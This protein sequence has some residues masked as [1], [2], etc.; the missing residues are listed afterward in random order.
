MNQFPSEET[1]FLLQGPAGLIEVLTSVPLHSPI[2]GSAIICHPHPLFGGT[3]HNKVVTMLARVFHDLGLRT[4][5]FNFRGIGKS[6]GEHDG[7][8]GETDDV[9]TIAEWI[10]TVCPEEALWLAGFSFGG[11]VA[12]SAA[13]RLPVKQLVSIAPMVSRFREANLPSI[14]CPWLIVQGEEDEVISP[15]ETYAW[16]ETLQPKPRLIRMPHAG[17]FFHGKLMELRR[18]L[19]AALNEFELPDD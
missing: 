16:I 13:T 17:H 12:V 14:T 19:T 3:M 15:E 2:K 6:H 8:R 9:V 1:T 18:V 5:R 11:F 7:G 10:K 4:V